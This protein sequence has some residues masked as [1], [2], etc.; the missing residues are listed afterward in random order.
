M[1]IFLVPATQAG[2]CA[3]IFFQ[4]TVLSNF[5]YFIYVWSVY[6]HQNSA[7]IMKSYLFLFTTILLSLTIAPAVSASDYSIPKVSVT[8]DIMEDGTVSVSERYTYHFKGAFSWAEVSVP[9]AGFSEIRNIRVSEPGGQYINENSGETGTFSVTK[10]S[11]SVNVRWHYSAEDTSKVFTLSYELTDAIIVG[12]E[13][14]EFYRNY[15]SSSRDKATEEFDITITFPGSV[16]TDQLYAWSQISGQR[17]EISNIGETIFLQASNISRRQTAI[18]HAVFPIYL[19]DR[20]QVQITNPEFTLEQVLKEEESI[21]KEA[22]KRAERDAFYASVTIEV[23]IIISLLSI[24][25]FIFLYRRYGSRH[26]TGTLSERETLV[27]PDQ[28]PPALVGRLLT[29]SMTTGNH[30]VATIFDLAR[31]GWFIIREKKPDEEKN[32]GWFSAGISEKNEFIISI[33]EDT[34]SDNLRSYESLAV[35]FVS[36]RIENGDNTFSKIL[37]GSDSKTA[38]WYAKWQKKVKE[39]F[40]EMEWIDKKSYHGLYLN[41]AGQSAFLAAAIWLIIFGNEFALIAIGVTG[42]ML[43][44]SFLIVRRTKTGEEVYKRWK[45]YLKGLKN[46]DKRTVRMET[47]DRHFIYATAFHLSEKQVNTLIESTGQPSAQ[48]FPWIIL[49]QGSSHTPA[50]IAS[51]VSA[52]ASS[53]TASF[54]GVSGGTGAVAGS[55]SGGSSA[56]AG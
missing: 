22:E 10:E 18:I 17:E 27:I 6:I 45:S 32:N 15:L 12:S 47:L 38:S 11:G 48:L 29:S 9:F 1:Q 7:F 51:S 36:E 56:S 53:G 16:E 40:D 14:S 52:L 5:Y 4:I 21:R 28:N 8:V 43:T 34:P 44:G 30:L 33:G 55:V 37:S 41:L 35:D 42:L 24:V 2:A 39:S 26:S 23:T 25:L 54:S 46:A 3:S 20:E 31:R 13:Y 19:F 49:M 50:T